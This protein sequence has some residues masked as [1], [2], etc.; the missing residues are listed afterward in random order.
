MIQGWI[1]NRSE[2][3]VSLTLID[4]QGNPAEIDA[5][6]DTGCTAAF[7]LP[8]TFVEEL[9]LNYSH[10]DPVTLADG[11]TVLSEVYEGTILWDGVLATVPIHLT[12]TKSLIGMGLLQGCRLTIDVIENGFVRIERLENPTAE[13][14]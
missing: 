2:A 8:R 1:E 10:D 14:P 6:I 13:R 9:G 11:S 12:D 4:P 5:V 7:T 3:L